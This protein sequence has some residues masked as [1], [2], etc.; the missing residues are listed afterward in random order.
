VL[1]PFEELL[2]NLC[3][4]LRGRL[5]RAHQR[6]DD[7]CR[8]PLL[9]ETD[10]G[11]KRCAQETGQDVIRRRGLAE[12]FAA[13]VLWRHAGPLPP[14]RTLSA[15]H[16]AGIASIY[17][18]A[19]GGGTLSRPEADVYAAGIRRLMASLKALATLRRHGVPGVQVNIAERQVNIAGGDS[20]RY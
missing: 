2:E 6:P 14:G 9:V 13:P 1:R 16:D 11:W 4:R 17:A 15:A 3:D 12:A 19:S 7:V 8:D 18:E 10:R 5:T 20:N